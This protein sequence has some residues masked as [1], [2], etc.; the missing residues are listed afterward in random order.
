MNR[1][2]NGAPQRPPSAMAGRTVF[3]VLVAVG[4]GL[5]VLKNAFDDG[6]SSASPSTTVAAST[7][8]PGETTSSVPSDIDKQSFKTLVANASGV[9]GSAG[10]WTEGLTNLG[11]A[12]VTPAANASKSGLPNTTVYFTP[13]FDAQAALVATTM[14]AAA[15]QPW[16]TTNAPVG[17]IKDANVVVTLG[18]DLAG[19]T[20]PTSVAPTQPATPAG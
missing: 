15:P 7:T 20:P 2:V 19:K 16:P 6:G 13:G 18:Q 9:A 11:F 5:L 3:V 1:P 8:A 10:K 12:M 17:D 4:L 14:G